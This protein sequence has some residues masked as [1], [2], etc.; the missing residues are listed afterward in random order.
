MINHL[1]D[2]EKQLMKQ[3]KKIRCFYCFMSF[4]FDL[5]RF[6]LQVDNPNPPKDETVQSVG[7][8]KHPSL[9]K[10]TMDTEKRKEEERT[11]EAAQ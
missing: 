3:L 6:F 4:C 5:V 7:T 8:E 10:T 9:S 1:N 2:V 11:R